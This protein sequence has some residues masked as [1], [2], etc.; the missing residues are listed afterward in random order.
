MMTAAIEERITKIL[1]DDF[2]VRYESIGS[3]TR[4]ADL[5]FDSLVIVELALVLDNEFGIAL[6]DGELTET[7][8]ITDVAELIVV[9]GA[10]A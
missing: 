1:L 3:D 8:T 2:K 4:F 9:K 5:S 7:M 10:V 6:E